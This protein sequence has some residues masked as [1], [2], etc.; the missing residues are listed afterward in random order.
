MKDFERL[1][2]VSYI[3]GDGRYVIYP[4]YEKGQVRARM[5]ELLNRIPILRPLA[6]RLN[7]DLLI[8]RLYERPG[9]LRAQLR[10][11][12]DANHRFYHGNAFQLFSPKLSQDGQHM[13]L[14]IDNLTSGTDDQGH[15]T[16]VFSR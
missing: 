10:C 3:T 16:L 7:R 5:C 4:S 11:T 9:I 2:N 1:S 8:L 6:D 12:E 13:V 14:S 15:R